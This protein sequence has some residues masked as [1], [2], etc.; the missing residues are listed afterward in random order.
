M[1]TKISNTGSGPGPRTLDGCSV[2]FWK[3]LKPG[4]EPDL[5]SSVVPAGGSILELGAGAGRITHALVHRAFDVTAV[6]NS[7]EMLAEITGAKTCLS[8]IEDLVL[9]QRFDA[10]VLGSCLINAPQFG[11]RSA[12]LKTCRRHLASDGVVL[13]QW[14]GENWPGENVRAGSSHQADGILHR[15]DEIRRDGPLVHM[16]LRYETPRGVWTHSFIFEPLDKCKIETTLMAAGLRFNRFLDCEQ[17]WIVA[18]AI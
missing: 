12:L 11:S 13:I 2:E 14:Y 10:V 16:T 3:Q 7:P 18:S 4:A 6:D 1:P 8:N 17:T 5:I 15:I 9:D